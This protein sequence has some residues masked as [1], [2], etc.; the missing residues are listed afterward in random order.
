M[1]EK[2]KKIINQIIKLNKCIKA[3][4]YST[5]YIVYLIYM[6]RKHTFNDLGVISFCRRALNLSNSPLRCDGNLQE[7]ALT[8]KPNESRNAS[9]LKKRGKDDQ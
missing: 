5:F 4:T 3:E 1:K 7:Q 8:R 2:S 9:G 6:E